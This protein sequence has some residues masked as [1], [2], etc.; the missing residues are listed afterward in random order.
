LFNSVIISFLRFLIANNEITPIINVIK[1]IHKFEKLTNI[2]RKEIDTQKNVNPITMIFWLFKSFI[3]IKKRNINVISIKIPESI[4]HNTIEMSD[5]LPP[6]KV[7]SNASLT[8]YKI[9]PLYNVKIKK[10]DEVIAEIKS[11][12]FVVIFKVINY[13]R[14]LLVLRSMH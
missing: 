2:E 6:T 5:V 10:K 7:S 11:I 8:K 4:N 9:I 14:T 1:V 13:S 12:D 3:F